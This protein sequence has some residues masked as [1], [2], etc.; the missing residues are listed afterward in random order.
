M[1]CSITGNIY[2]LKE[3]CRLALAWEC[4]SQQSDISSFCYSLFLP[5]FSVL[6]LNFRDLAAY[7]RAKQRL[8]YSIAT[9][10]TNME[11]RLAAPLRFSVALTSGILSSLAQVPRLPLPK[12][13]FVSSLWNVCTNVFCLTRFVPWRETR[14][15]TVCCVIW[16][17]TVEGHF[18]FSKCQ[19]FLRYTRKCDSQTETAA[20]AVLLHKHH[21]HSTAFCADP[22]TIGQ[23][24]RN[25]WTSSNAVLQ[26]LR[27]FLRNLLFSGLFLWAAAAADFIWMADICR[28]MWEKL[29]VRP[30]I[31]FG[32]NFTECFGMSQHHVEI[33]CNEF[34]ADCSRTVNCAVMNTFVL[35]SK[36]WIQ[37]G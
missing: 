31:R 4:S 18:V 12:T 35:R 17:S 9:E 37:R 3:R 27:H 36:V 26:F 29:L 24:R 25:S 23:W 6:T 8:S 2:R 10:P 15:L 20:F 21:K 22:N 16:A 33:S 11:R 32:F 13:Y 28:K 7:P 5:L 14:Q 1:R 34:P 19:P 30:Y